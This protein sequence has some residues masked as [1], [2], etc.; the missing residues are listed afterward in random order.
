[1]FLNRVDFPLA[2]PSLHRFLSLNSVRDQVVA[3]EPNQAGDVKIGGKT[4]ILFFFMFSQAFAKIVRNAEVN[5][6]FL[7]VAEEI[8]VT[9][10]H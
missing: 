5:C 7:S 2:G 9:I 4:F 8:N 1:M 6:A 3:I 10:A